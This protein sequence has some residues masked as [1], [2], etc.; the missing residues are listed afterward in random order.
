MFSKS[1]LA[2]VAKD[3]LE[4]FGR[5]KDFV[6]REKLFALQSYSGKAALVVKGVRRCGKS[7]LLKQ[8]MEGQ[9]DNQFY[10]FNFD[11]DRV[12]GFEA[13]DF[14][15]LME[16]F[17]EV[18]GKKPVVFFD[19]IQIVHGWELFINRLLRE[20]YKVFIT[21]SNADLLSRE[22]GTHLTGRHVDF[23][24]YPFSFSEFLTAKKI[25][26]P[27]AG[28]STLEKVEISKAFNEFLV[29]GGMPEAIVFDNDAILSQVI[30]DIIQKDVI[31]RYNLRKPNEFRNVLNFL[32]NN[33]GNKIT[34]NSISKNFQIRSS[35]TVQKYVG[36][37]E[38]AYLVFMVNLF[39][40]KIK[41]LEKNPKKI[42]CVDNGIVAK[43]SLGILE[44]K[45][46]LLENLVAIELKRRGQPFYYYVNKN[47]SET[48][49]VIETRK[50]SQAIQVCLNPN[51]SQ[52]Q[53]REQKALLATINELKLKKGL[54]I[55]LDFEETKK[56]DGK[57]IEY[58]TAWKW[59]LKK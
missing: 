53:E 8:L 1:A 14:Q 10:Y 7:T 31:R 15:V 18:F 47:G 12:L 50:G 32:L 30:N 20:D 39:D 41:R 17:L 45:G 55:T 4:E 40:K 34:Y 51:E 35:N 6:V 26:I 33:V 42:Y 3:Q 9:F 43:N 44:K 13:R 49:F 22:L 21:G 16:T 52:T 27:S 24:L 46:A 19:E 29:R 25:G 59:L 56:I 5:L 23:E 58:S 28:F 54:V 38:E 37:A 11:D 48:D 36:Y 2:N 57:T